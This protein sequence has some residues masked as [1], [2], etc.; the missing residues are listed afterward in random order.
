MNDMELIKGMLKDILSILGKNT[1]NDESLKSIADCT[2]RALDAL[3]VYERK[4]K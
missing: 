2:Q 3:G 4:A 1:N